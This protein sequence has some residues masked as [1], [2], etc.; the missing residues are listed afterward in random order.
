[1]LQQSDARWSMTFCFFKVQSQPTTLMLPAA[2]IT[3][4]ITSPATLGVPTPIPNFFN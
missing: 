3:D 2:R 1:M 4:L